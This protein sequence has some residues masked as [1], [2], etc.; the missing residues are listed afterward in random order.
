MRRKIDVSN[1]ATLK[2]IPDLESGTHKNII[3]SEY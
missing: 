3:F 1:S 2:E